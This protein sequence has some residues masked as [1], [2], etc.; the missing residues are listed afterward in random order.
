MRAIFRL[1]YETHACGIEPLVA[2][3]WWNTTME[4]RSSQDDEDEVDEEGKEE[5]GR[6]D[7]R[8]P[9]TAVTGLD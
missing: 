4:R 5:T 3:Y 1:H 9:L 8:S 7:L 2:M 6:M